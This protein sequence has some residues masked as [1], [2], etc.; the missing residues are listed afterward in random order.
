MMGASL[1][2]PA[3][4]MK[5]LG[6]DDMR[7]CGMATV[8]HTVDLD[9]QMLDAAGVM[10]SL[11]YLARYGKINWDHSSEPEHLLGDI[12]HAEIRK[13]AAG[14]GL[15]IEATLNPESKKAR[16]VYR[17]MK[18]GMKLG[19][20]VQGVTL[21]LAKAAHMGFPVEKITEAFVNEVAL[22][23][24]PKNPYT[25]AAILK[26]VDDAAIRKALVAGSGTDAAQ[27]TGGRA[28]TQ[29]QF[30]PCVADLTTLARH[31]R[32]KYGVPAVAHLAKSIEE[33][34]TQWQLSP[35]AKRKLADFLGRK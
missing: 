30:G 34:S 1:W 16:L 11:A 23:H 22:T 25:F 24:R 15:Y 20:S 6:A 29:E 17:L 10:D 3:R 26:S 27:F 28:L 5:G 32:H 13:S 19:F 18:G 33:F 35:G 21:K 31:F 4:I 8:D 12:T 7:I 2:V 14:R 9:G